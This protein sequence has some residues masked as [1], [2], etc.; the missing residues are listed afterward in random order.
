MGSFFW[1]RLLFSCCFKSFG[2][3][4]ELREAFFGGVLEGVEG[5]GFE[6]V[7]GVD[8][9]PGGDDV[10]GLADGSHLEFDGDLAE[11]FDGASAAGVSVSDHGDGFVVPAVVDVVESVF[12]GSGVAVVVFGSNE[13]EGVGFFDFFGEAL[14]GFLGVGFFDGAWRYGFDKEGHWVIKKIENFGVEVWE[15]FGLFKHPMGGFVAKAL[16]AD[17]ADDDFELEHRRV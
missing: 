7:L 11:L 5:A 9:I 14:D 17:T 16:I 4:E 15:L 12:E 3:P 1:L 6:D 13:D 10:D 2:P 8:E